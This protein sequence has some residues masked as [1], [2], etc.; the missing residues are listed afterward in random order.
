MVMAQ[1]IV[2][3][4]PDRFEAWKMLYS[5]RQ[6]IAREAAETPDQ[7]QSIQSEKWDISSLENQQPRK[8]HQAHGVTN[9]QSHFK[10]LIAS[11]LLSIAII[12]AI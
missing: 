2:S 11:S 6:A 9:F 8:D 12:L 4:E 3:S 5:Q 7:D 1:P 10:P